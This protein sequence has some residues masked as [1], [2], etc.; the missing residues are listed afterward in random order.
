MITTKVTLEPEAYPG[1]PKK[2]TAV[3]LTAVLDAWLLVLSSNSTT[4]F[5]AVTL[6]LTLW[7]VVANNLLVVE[8]V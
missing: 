4:V 2:K 7:E 5:Q 6:A 1:S 3:C 8:A